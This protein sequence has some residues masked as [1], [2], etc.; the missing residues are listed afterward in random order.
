[1]KYAF[2]REHETQYPVRRLC[3]VMM[4]H[5]SGYYSWHLRPEPIR[6]IEDRRLLGH[7]K[8]S[9]PES[10]VVYDYRKVYDDLGDL[11]ESCGRNRVH[12]L[13]RKDSLHVQTGYHRRPGH[14]KGAPPLLRRTTCN[15]NLMSPSRTAFGLPLLRTFAR[16]RAGYSL[17]Q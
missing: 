5:T 16:M 17:L 12:R 10:G 1:M 3:K 14:L 2:I 15:N 9:W 6:S 13:M 7:I 4:V 11:G 8:Q